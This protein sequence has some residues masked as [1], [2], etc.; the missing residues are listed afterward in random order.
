[1]SDWTNQPTNVYFYQ[2]TSGTVILN[3]EDIPLNQGSGDSQPICQGTTTVG[4]NVWGNIEADIAGQTD[5]QRHAE[6][7][8]ETGH[9]QSLGHIPG[10][11]LALLG[12]NPNN[13][14]Y[15]VPQQRDLDLVN[16][17]YP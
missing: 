12:N 2:S 4:Y 11:D 15:V 16:Q 9:P 13:N 3:T 6:A 5:N 14:V 17:V 10:P 8:H 7:G 1:V